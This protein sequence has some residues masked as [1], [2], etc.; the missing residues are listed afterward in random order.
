MICPL[1]L[2]CYIGSLYILLYVSA[3]ALKCYRCYSTQE[4]CGKELSIRLN[5]LNTC[6]G[7]EYGAGENFCVKVIEKRGSEYLTI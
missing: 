3:N 1:I 7:L 4:G 2:G 5:R 6:P